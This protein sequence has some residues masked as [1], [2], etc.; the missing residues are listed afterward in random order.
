MRV[1]VVGRVSMDLTALDVTAIP[2]S[3]LN[4]GQYVELFGKGVSVDEVAAACGTISYEILTGLGSRL[5]R[6]YIE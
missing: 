2:S 6:V 3:D 5:E 1:P 4:V